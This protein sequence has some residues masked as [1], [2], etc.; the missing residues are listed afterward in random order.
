MLVTVTIFFL[1]LAL[2][3]K[4]SV[5]NI[6]CFWRKPALVLRALLA[7]LLLVPLEVIVLMK[8]FHLPPE[9]TIGLALLAAA[10]GAPLSTK[11]AQIAG[12]NLG[13]AASLQL[14]LVILAVFVT[15]STL[16]IFAILFADISQKV[17]ILDVARQVMMVQIL[18]V[19]LGLFINK[20]APTFAQRIAQ[21][22]TLIADSLFFGLVI[23]ACIFGL[24]LLYKLWVLPLGAI[25]IMVIASLGI[26]HALG[27]FDHYTRS[28]LAIFCVARNFGL[29]LFIA[30]LNDVEQQVI[31]TL[32]AYL[33]LG[34]CIGVPYSIWN[35]RRLAENPS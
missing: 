8:F 15:P 19:S 6:L 24:P 17:A 5:E 12:G 26:G 20:F 32:V 28:T 25:S 35:K 27:R 31:P 10:P 21:P 30:I 13:Y 4:L 16:A 2:G 14:T 33:I 29:A 3:S 7:V 1:M 23:L 18:P 11:R 22:L 9:V 34:T